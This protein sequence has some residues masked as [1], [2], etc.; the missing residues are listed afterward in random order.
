MN[1]IVVACFFKAIYNSIFKYL[2]TISFKNRELF[3]L[4]STYFDIIEI[5]S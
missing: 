2:L 1:L 5:N 3:G 4:I